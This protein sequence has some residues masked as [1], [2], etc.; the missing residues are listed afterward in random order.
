MGPAGR[1]G[2]ALVGSATAAT[3]AQT[4]WTANK[5]KS[6]SRSRIPRKGKVKKE[7]RKSAAS[8]SGSAK[9]V[10]SSDSLK[11]PRNEGG[12]GGGSK[13]K[14]PKMSSKAEKAQDELLEKGR[15]AAMKAS[16][17]MESLWQVQRKEQQLCQ[18][19][20][21]IS[22]HIAGQATVAAKHFAVLPSMGNA[23]LAAKGAAA[24]CTPAL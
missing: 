12:T 2:R 9:K 22:A 6:R 17:P 23:V 18:S 13:G 8:N 15:L 24:M 5:A 11:R 16:H 21:W 10:P 19:A 3:G 14:A 4:A 20:S 1:A 7:K